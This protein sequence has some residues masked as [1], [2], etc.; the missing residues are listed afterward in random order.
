[1]PPWL[2]CPLGGGEFQGRYHADFHSAVSRD[3]GLGSFEPLVVAPIEQCPNGFLI[4]KPNY[5]KAELA[6]IAKLI[7]EPAFVKLRGRATY[8]QLWWLRRAEGADPYALAELLYLAARE[9]HASPVNE[10]RQS[11]LYVAAVAQL[12]FN[13]ERKDRWFQANLRAVNLWREQGR[14]EEA[15][16]LLVALSNDA[17]K[18]AG[19]KSNDELHALSLLIEE[20]NSDSYPVTLRKP[21]QAAYSCLDSG[22][23]LT[24]SEQIHCASREVREAM[25]QECRRS[26][27][28][29][30]AAQ[31]HAACSQF[32]RFDDIISA[33]AIALALLLLALTFRG[34][35]RSETH[36]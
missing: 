16:E 20:R 4:A 14:F 29:A 31:L 3:R 33:L 11:T 7:A 26:G 30:A 13:F 9:M 5:S 12:P 19:N 17:L 24:K 25:K 23:S 35:T 22:R 32:R 18:P 27:Y 34:L 21:E 1:M 10:L 36:S 8:E 6:Q 15:K 2:T 28:G